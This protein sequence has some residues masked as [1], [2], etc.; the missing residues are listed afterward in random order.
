MP[1]SRLTQESRHRVVWSPSV[2]ARARRSV[3]PVSQ[4]LPI[5]LLTWCHGR[6]CVVSQRRHQ[7]PWC[8]PSVTAWVAVL[9]RCHD[10]EWL[11]ASVFSQ[12]HGLGDSLLVSQ[13]VPGSLPSRSRCGVALSP[14]SPHVP[15]VTALPGHVWPGAPAAAPGQDPP[16]APGPGRAADGA[17]EDA[18][19]LPPPFLP[20]RHRGW[21]RAWTGDGVGELPGPVRRR[22]GRAG[23]RRT[24]PNRVKRSRTEGIP[25]GPNQAERSRTET[26]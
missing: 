14:L 13:G 22:P 9:P 18:C 16:P 1:G 25:A 2:T 23:P 12:C 11:C 3:P 7:A 15:P 26:S 19:C 17:A 20:G 5:W 24:E 8:A 6:G 4:H 21:T 10:M